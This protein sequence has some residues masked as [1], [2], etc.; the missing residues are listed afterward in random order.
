ML[1]HYSFIDSFKEVLK[2][3]YRIHLSHTPIP[4]E[5]FIVNVMEEIPVPDKQGQVQILHEIG[6]QAIPF[7]RAVDQYP[8]YAS[9]SDIEYLFRALNAEQVIDIFMALLLEK[10][11]L[12]ISKYK[13]LLTHASIAL[14]SFLFPLCWKNTWIP[15]LPRNMT[16]VL[17]APFPFLIGVDP[18]ILKESEAFEI[19]NEVYRVDLDMGF[20]SPRDAK[21]KLPSKEYK[22]LK[23]RLIKATEGVERPGLDMVEQAFNVVSWQEQADD[24][25][26]EARR[27]NGYEV[28][29][30]FL[31][32]MTSIMQGYTKC[33]VSHD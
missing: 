11:V 9:R 23:Q 3:L 30:A 12:L 27:F 22:A 20:I 18:N 15:I 29:D 26:E 17:D 5:R 28:R 6:N 2:Q 13:A 25:D 31:E 4:I 33:L 16:D 21:P 10:K 19:P 8:P 32:F 1:S 24:E 14:I 7:Y